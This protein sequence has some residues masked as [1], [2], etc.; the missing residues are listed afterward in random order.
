MSITKRDL[1]DQ[2]VSRSP[3]MV[4]CA[5]NMY[6]VL[7]RTL[8]AAPKSKILSHTRLIGHDGQTLFW[9]LLKTYQSTTSQIISAT[10]SKLDNLTDQLKSYKYDIDKFCDYGTKLL[11]TLTGDVG[12]ES[13]AFDKFYKALRTSHNSNFNSTLSVWRSVQ[14]RTGVVLEIGKLLLKAREEY[15]GMIVISTWSDN[16]SVPKRSKQDRDI[17]ALANGGIQAK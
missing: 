6:I 11:A 4:E 3:A 12:S 14:D 8:G 16:V 1:L 17:A 5:C 13:Q 2:Q 10:L 15:R 7:W 9:V